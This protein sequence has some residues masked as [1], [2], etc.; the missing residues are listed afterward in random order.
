MAA[1]DITLRQGRANPADI[2]LHAQPGI[3]PT[4]VP[5]YL[6]PGAASPKDI[7][8]R[9]PTAAPVP[10]GGTI[11]ATA[12]IT[13]APDTLAASAAIKIQATA[14]I[15]EEPD[16]IAAAASIKIQAAATTTED[17]DTQTATATIK[18]QA[19][20]TITE[21]ADTLDSAAT[22]VTPGGSINAAANITE[23]DDTLSATAEIR[24]KGAGKPKRRNYNFPAWRHRL[25]FTG[26]W[27]A[28]AEELEGKLSAKQRPT[29][30]ALE[31]PEATPPAE[32]IPEPARPEP[33]RKPQARL[34]FTG[35]II[36]E[37][38]HLRG[39]LELLD[40]PEPNPEDIAE[41][42]ELLETRR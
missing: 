7:I 37:K 12:A 42:A 19:T 25:T 14:A 32:F 15:T 18:I 36:A 40:W 22:V 27:E 4:L 34:S 6:R 21:A 39:Q 30:D 23:A 29:A 5:I 1:G 28:P 24:S 26:E 2:T 38:S 8:L 13:E 35:M 31:L 10:S 16:T 17:P 9:D 33:A 11:T 3:A 41:I 20:A